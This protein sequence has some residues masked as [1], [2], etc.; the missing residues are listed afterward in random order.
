MNGFGQVPKAIFF[1]RSH[2]K[3]IGGPRVVLLQGQQLAEFNSFDPRANGHRQ[4]RELGLGQVRLTH[5]FKRLRT[6]SSQSLARQD[7]TN[8][9]IF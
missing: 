1:L 2:V 4:S 3:Q 5:G 6:P 9:P 7:P 8:G